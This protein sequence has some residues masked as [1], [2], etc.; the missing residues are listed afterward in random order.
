MIEFNIFNGNDKFKMGFNNDET[1]IELKKLIAQKL[2][3][4][5]VNQFNI[6]LEKTGFIDIN[7]SLLNSKISSLK[8]GLSESNPPYSIFCFDKLH[9]ENN[10]ESNNFCFNKFIPN[11]NLSQVGVKIKEK[12]NIIV[13]LSC[14]KHCNNIPID[15]LA[16]DD[17]I[18]D[19]NFICECDSNK[20]KKSTSFSVCECD[21]N[22]NI[23]I[24]KFSN[25]NLNNIIIE[26]N[27]KNEFTN[28]CT[29]LLNKKKD[30]IEQFK[31]KEKMKELNKK[32]LQR[33][34]EFME[35][36]HLF[37][38]RIAS[39]KDKE[40][41]KKII[42]IIPK[43]PLGS[44]SEQYVK[45][46]LK[47][48]KKEFFSWCN[49]PKCPQC[50]QNDKNLSV[51]SYGDKPNSEEKNFLA[52]RTEKYI[53]NNCNKEVRFARYNKTIKLLETRTGRCSEWS[54]LFGGILY[55]CGFKVRLINNFEDHVW[56]EFYNEEEKRWIHIDSCEEAYDTPL[57]YEQGWGRVMT[58][59]L[60]LSDDGLVEVTPRY[61]KDWKI[62]NER[63]S[64]K[65][66]IKL[67]KIMEEVNKKMM[68]GINPEEMKNIEERRKNE[69]ESFEKK[70]KL[71][72]FGE[73]NINVN[74]AEKIGRQS[75]SL[76]WRKNR[77]EC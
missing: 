14:A 72:L 36:I 16:P 29:S 68:A 58:F 2:N 41:Q 30:E 37:E 66:I 19:K 71:D 31:K 53:C 64:E 61:V 55:T 48:Y 20:N 76:E 74:D 54:N 25:F 57:V 59:I 17:L 35:I 47:W 49:K 34:F 40:M 18:T 69:I 62:V 50:G 27:E 23:K 22:K 28:K 39:Y 21:S 60:G 67:Q 11:N 73:G 9:P 70:I 26:Q 24:C 65:M 45:I 4:S 44:T 46:L 15:Y 10:I 6:F 38:E 3:I 51:I 43:R 32:I 33:D 63:R 12:D 42:E 8:Q 1:I 77:G 13:C 75:G 56:N 52:Y 7:P 5:D